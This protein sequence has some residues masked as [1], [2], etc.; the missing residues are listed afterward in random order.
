MNIFI[1][2]LNL[3]IGAMNLEVGKLLAEIRESAKLTQK[4]IAE[5]LQGN[6]TKVS[7][8]EAGEGNL[9][10]VLGYLNVV[11]STQAEH[12]ASLL[13]LDWHYLAR[14]SLTH[15]DMETLIAVEAALVRIHAF[16]ED[17]NVPAVLAN[18]A[19]LLIGRLLQ[20]GNYLLSLSHEVVYVGEI[21]VGKTTAACQQAGLVVDAASAADLKGM[22][23]DTGG[24]RTTLCDVRVETGDRYSLAV[25]AV[26]DEEVYRLVSETCKGVLEK[27][28]GVIG[29]TQAEFKP[30]E[31]VERALRN[32]AGLP[33]PARAKK[34]G[35]AAPDP[36]AELSKTFKT[37]AELSAEFAG[38]LSLWRRKRRVVE[39]EGRDSHEARRWLKET[40]TAINNGRHTDFSLPAK[41]TVTVPFAL[42]PTNDLAVAVVDTRG[43]DGSAVRRD[44]LDHMKDERAVTLLCS[45]WGSAPDPSSQELLKHLAET[46]ADKSL[47]G[48][49]AVIA[50][51]R[52]G[53][54][55]SMRHDSGEAAEDTP[56]G[57]DIKL[58]QVE[59][60]LQKV[61]MGG[62]NSFAFDASSDD[63]RDLSD[64]I[65]GQIQSIRQTQAAAAL[66]TIEAADEMLA[67]IEQAAA[68]AALA[69]VNK[70]LHIFATRHSSLPSGYRAPYERLLN[71]VLIQHAR[72]V[73][74]TTLRAGHF[75]NFDVYQ[76]LGDGAAGE[77]K[78]RSSTVMAGL[79][80]II[81]NRRSDEE[82]ASVHGY[83]AEILANSAT[84]ETDF[85]NAARHHAVAVY[86]DALN[87][88]GPMWAQ[89]ELPYGSGRSNYRE[90]VANNLRNWF[91]QKNDLREELERRVGRAWEN[92]VMTPLRQI[93]GFIVDTEAGWACGRL[94]IDPGRTPD[95]LNG[96][97][98]GRPDIMPAST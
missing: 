12:L 37:E 35:A 66:A 91:E 50:I 61:G 36:V 18:Q 26:A 62:I 38:K 64:F 43:V 67:N 85:V 13:R 56:E 58:A 1:L 8:I 3:E 92:S 27:L 79:R 51:A 53:D 42:L 83:L 20:A 16:L 5:G 94:A 71:A 76:Y 6:Q 11:G 89:C 74:A 75:W 7:R 93:S 15:P 31:E 22:L 44:I 9:E 52:T 32:M 30:A 63:P 34:G 45:K 33:R 96:G 28:N 40:F 54:A 49:L 95:E 29:V 39:F 24:G 72:S 78:V 19:Q 48:R 70:D 97:G 57:Y 60:A 23:L 68:L 14:P 25:D 82:L 65:I 77:A 10:D 98:G 2:D 87:S 86:A 4:Q 21:G 47:F 46:D 17:G 41:I 88:A 84:W 69:H 80:E 59:D 90:Y 73:W 81:E 55:L